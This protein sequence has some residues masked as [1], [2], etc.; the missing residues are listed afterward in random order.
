MTDNPIENPED[1]AQLAAS[2]TLAPRVISPQNA[3]IMTDLLKDAVARG[4]GR[5]ARV[6]NRTDLAGKTGTT[7][8]QVDAWFNGFNSNIATSVWVGFDNPRSLG[9]YAAQ[10]ALP[11]WVQYM[12]TALEDMP[13]A[14]MP[15]PPGLVS[16]RI[17]PETGLLA[18]SS[19]KDAIFEIFREEHVPRTYA[20]QTM[21]NPFLPNAH[22]APEMLF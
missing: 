17:D 11:M 5:G 20:P 9:E 15:E 16:V 4:T 14:T 21:D 3:Y 10:A 6:L 1:N 2:T 19:Q 12:R 18:P 8:G 22:G 7:N 13:E